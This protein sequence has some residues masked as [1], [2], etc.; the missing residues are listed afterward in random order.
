M[1]KQQKH[2][3]SKLVRCV[4]SPRGQFNLAAKIASFSHLVD[5]FAAIPNFSPSSLR[6]S[7]DLLDTSLFSSTTSTTTTT[8]YYFDELILWNWAVKE[9]KED[10]VVVSSK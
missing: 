7:L 10:E 9:E 4:K 5:A 1:K 3:P 6:A 2:K 8:L